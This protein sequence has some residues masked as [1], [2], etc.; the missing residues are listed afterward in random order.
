VVLEDTQMPLYYVL[1]HFVRNILG[2]STLLMRLPSYLFGCLALWQHFLFANEEKGEEVALIS[3]GFLS[4]SFMAILHTNEMRPYSLLLFLSI[5]S[6]RI[7]YKFI[8]DQKNLALLSCFILVS[9]LLVLTHYYGLLL[10]CVQILWLLFLIGK[11]Q[12]K[13]ARNPALI[14]ICV[15]AAFLPFSRGFI[16]N[17]TVVHEYRKVVTLYDYVSMAAYFSSG[18]Y[19]LLLILGL[20]GWTLKNNYSGTTARAYLKENALTFWILFAPIFI[21]LTKNIFL[22]PSLEPRYIIFCLSP[23]SII[24]A[25]LFLNG[26]KIRG[27]LLLLAVVLLMGNIFIKED[28]LHTPYRIDSRQASQQAIQLSDT[29]RDS[30]IVACNMCSHYYFDKQKFYC[31]NYH[32]G[33]KAAE[34]QSFMLNLPLIKNIVLVELMAFPACTADKNFFQHFSVKE[35]YNFKGY[36]VSLLIKDQND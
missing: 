13:Y 5:V 34:I 17:L 12:I 14:F 20:I 18:K 9:S 16:N 4:L 21:A 32:N 25:P 26:T 27:P 2:D 10:F 8:R 33:M 36:K 6:F 11:N 7:F 1:I 31:L 24:I 28:Y 35:Y 15:F 29:N 22:N 23:F 3:T 19:F 30:V